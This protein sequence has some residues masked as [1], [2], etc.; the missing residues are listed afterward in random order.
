MLLYHM[1]L[2]LI[3]GLLLSPTARSKGQEII[4][5]PPKCCQVPNVPLLPCTPFLIVLGFRTNLGSPEVTSSRIGAIE[6]RWS[7]GS[8][9]PCSAQFSSARLTSPLQ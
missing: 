6:H 5:S 2:N 7:T 1:V 3:T 8:P 9:A 4:Q